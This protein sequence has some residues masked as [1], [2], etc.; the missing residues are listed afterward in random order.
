MIPQTL[1][2]GRAAHAAVR[3][4]DWMPVR[5][6]GDASVIL[7]PAAARR[8]REFEAGNH[9][10][11][12]AIARL[13]AAPVA[14]GA[15]GRLEDGSPQWPDGIVGSITHT[16]H[17][18]AAAVMRAEDASGLGLD[19]EPLMSRNRAE[20]VARCIGSAAELSLIGE[21][22]ALGPHEALTVIFSAKESIFKCLYPRVRRMFDYR[23][24][25]LEGVDL[26]SGRFEARLLTTLS[27]EYRA[28]APLKGRVVIDADV[29]FTAMHV[30][31]RVDD[32]PALACL[33]H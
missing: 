21:Q 28:G 10:A 3:I 27:R 31:N 30:G 6:G 26:E 7:P 12:Q 11:A 9:C 14:S 32:R 25:V 13:L 18:A 22:A 24:A 1:L 16:R 23:A 29:V 20:K 19:A 4:D 17:L 15:I 33:P 5:P 2:P 8:R